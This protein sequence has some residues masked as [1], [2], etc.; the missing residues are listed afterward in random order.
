MPFRVDLGEP[1]AE[2]EAVVTGEGEGLAGGR[3][4]G[5]DGN[6]DD[7]EE[8]DGCEGGGASCRAEGVLEDVDE[9]EACWGSDGFLEVANAEKVGY[10][11]AKGHGD[12]E[13]ERP[14]H[15]SGNDCGCALDFL[16]HVGYGIRAEHDEHGGDLADHDRERS[17]RPAGAVGENGEHL[18]GR[19]LWG[20]DPEDDND[21][22]EGEDVNG[23]KDTFGE[24]EALCGEDVEKSDADHSRPDEEGTL[25]A[26]GDV[27]GV[28]KNDHALN[29]DTHNVRVDGDDALPGDCRK[30]SGNVTEQ[31]LVLWRGKLGNPMV[32]S[33]SRRGHGGHF[34]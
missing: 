1:V 15:G 4:E 12:V 32:L 21:R 27:F 25:P 28:V 10:K 26:G 7:Q 18:S 19:L 31:L 2:G 11:K 8:N 24:G 33:T 3:G 30:P 14:D 13:N 5:R 6:H 17:G 9:G 34:C 29:H 16:G 20:K 22:E 23:H